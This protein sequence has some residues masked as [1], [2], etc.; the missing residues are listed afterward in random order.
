MDNTAT[1]PSRRLLDPVERYSEILFGLIMVLTFTG[2][3]SASGLGHDEVRTM[4]IGA[5]GCNLA[6][7]IIDAVMYLMARFGERGR[8]LLAWRSV[9]EATD[10][11]E[12]RRVIA[13]AL[14]S[15]VASVLSAPE[16]EMIRTRLNQL[17]GMPGRSRLGRDDFLGAVGVF[18][19]VFLSTFPPVIPFL[20]VHDA[21]RALRISNGIAIGM[22]FV[23]GFLLGRHAGYH[24]WLVGISM[25]TIGVVL[26]G[27]TIALGG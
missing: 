4:L 24:P 19:L 27:V 23:L 22:L 17:S 26:V 25:V 14:P 13:D 20:F 12:A 1:Q 7:G 6:W 8:G 15:V 18:W 16:L 11:D 21:L 3:L 9:R 2:S 5:I 10:P